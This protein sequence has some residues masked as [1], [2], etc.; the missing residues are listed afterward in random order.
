[1]LSFCCTICLDTLDDAAR[2]MSTQCGHIYCMDCATF[3]F[4][5]NPSCAVCR[6]PQSL[7]NMIRLYPNLQ[8]EKTRKDASAEQSEDPLSSSPISVRSMDRAA[9]DSIAA[10]KQAIADRVDPEDAMMICNT[11]VNSVTDRGKQHINT[12]LLREISFQLNLM[13]T[14]INDDH[15]R[16]EKLMKNAKTARSSEK[17]LTSQLEKR[18]AAIDTLEKANTQLSSQVA[19]LNERIDTLEKQCHMSSENAQH[20]R[21]RA[22]KL[23]NQLE[24]AQQESENWKQQALKVKKKYLVLKSKVEEARRTAGDAHRGRARAASNDDD[25]VIVG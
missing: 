1:M 7:D 16:L 15:A 24:D 17:K 3:R 19:M 9:E 23:E 10:T 12:E 4:S 5:L 13:T 14:K 20:E 25:L 8:T 6:Q 18:Q 22:G 11:F 2:P 21:F